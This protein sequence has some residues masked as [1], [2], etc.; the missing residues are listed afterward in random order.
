MK[1]S[2]ITDALGSISDE[3]SREAIEEIEKNSNQNDSIIHDGKPRVVSE[4]KSRKAPIFIAL[5]GLC[6]AAAIALPFAL[7]NVGKNEI[8]ASENLS[9]AADSVVESVSENISESTA[10]AE[11]VF[12]N[13]HFKSTVNEDEISFTLPEFEDVSFKW[14]RQKVT[15][16]GETIAEGMYIYQVYLADLNGDGMREIVTSSSWSSAFTPESIEAYD[17][18]NKKFYV[19]HTSDYFNIL[20]LHIS[21]N[22]LWVCE[23]DYLG[24]NVLSDKKLELSDMKLYEN[25]PEVP[26]E[27][28]YSGLEPELTDNINIA[29]NVEKVRMSVNGGEL[30]AVSDDENPNVKIFTIKFDM[31]KA[32]TFAFV[33]NEDGTY[34][35]FAGDNISKEE[36]LGE[37][38]DAA[39][40]LMWL[41][42]N[43]GD[44]LS[45]LLENDKIHAFNASHDST[46]GTLRTYEYWFALD[47]EI[48]RSYEEFTQEGCA[49]GIRLKDNGNGT[50]SMITAPYHSGEDSKFPT[51]AEIA[52]EAVRNSLIEKASVSAEDAKEYVKNYALCDLNSDGENEILV[53][54][55]FG[56]PEVH[57]FERKGVTYE[58]TGVFLKEALAI[59]DL[60]WF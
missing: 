18:A 4:E 5:A 53:L 38:P 58:E 28:R 20:S 39:F 9:G 29:V 22:E 3:F 56:T 34:K 54:N 12:D 25:G 57:I 45:A 26:A 16:N 2:R 47:S 10:Q 44:E 42:K 50:Y 37:C 19:L 52:L 11:K 49:G 31:S 35:T 14:T 48:V 7:K 21:N 55:T 24:N 40:G 23:K 30:S 41:Y 33:I 43:G 27:E 36:I 17:Y 15:A 32:D 59:P 1:I 51:S 8:V 6:A 60:N 13:N 46:Q